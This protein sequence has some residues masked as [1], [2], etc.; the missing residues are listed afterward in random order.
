MHNLAG[1]R[2]VRPSLTNERTPDWAAIAPVRGST[3]RI[4]PHD[5]ED[6]FLGVNNSSYRYTKSSR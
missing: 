6:I 2:D 1:F 4:N 5:R 3:R